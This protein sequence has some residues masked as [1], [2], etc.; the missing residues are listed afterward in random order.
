MY[1]CRYSNNIFK[2]FSGNIMSEHTQTY[3]IGQH[4]LFTAIWSQPQSRAALRSVPA[5]L[6]AARPTDGQQTAFHREHVCAGGRVSQWS[7]FLISEQDC[8]NRVWSSVI[9][10]RTVIMQTIALTMMSH[11]HIKQLETMLFSAEWFRVNF[12]LLKPC[13]NVGCWCSTNCIVCWMYHCHIWSCSTNCSQWFLQF[14]KKMCCKTCC[15]NGEVLWMA[16]LVWRL[17]CT[18]LRIANQNYWSELLVSQT[19][20]IYF[21]LTLTI[22][23]EKALTFSLAT[24]IFYNIIS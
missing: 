4:S 2:A 6:A 12:I 13:R 10:E 8:H 1:L 18:D 15:R 11:T 19:R 24:K 21:T 17:L 22:T 7:Q 20:T 14:L 3:I 16:A 9:E 23:C 5:C